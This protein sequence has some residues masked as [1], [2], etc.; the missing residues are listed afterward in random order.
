MAWNQ[1]CV[2]S[3]RIKMM[4]AYNEGEVGVSE[5]ARQFGVSRKTTYKW[6]ERYEEGGWDALEDRSRAA[7]HHPNAVSA[8]VEA[9]VLRLKAQ[10][11][12]W[13]A[14]KLRRKLEQTVG[15]EHCPAE[16]TIS[17][18]LRRHGLSR[19]QR[20]RWRAVPSAQP[21]GH[22]REANAV[23]CADFK[24]WFRTGDGAKCTPLTIS[25]GHSR[26][27]LACQGLDGSTGWLTVQPLF[28]AAFRRYGMPQ[29]M[30]TDNGAPFATRGLAGL[31]AL[32]VWWL[33]LGIELER[34]EPGCRNKT[35][36]TSG[37]T[38]RSKPPPRN[39]RGPTCGGNRKPS[40]GS[41]RSTMKSVR[42][43]PWARGH[44][45]SFINH[46]RA[47]I[48]SACPSRA[49][50][51]MNGKSAKCARTAGSNGKGAASRSAAP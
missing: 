11:S 29:A 10:R 44:R 46:R 22:C 39:R 20:R 36:A 27:L 14:P 4:V 34:I 26:Y 21:L 47:S 49:A 13:G 42:T 19:V 9:E 2:M 12:L 15:A 41:G 7:H 35:G 16:S 6:I 33:Q 38:A 50:I 5:L 28:I 24:G 43:K 30:R 51:P 18:I 25:D 1:T 3:E 48:P 23:W 45:R 32:S 8:E 31:S 17:A 37:C 40:M